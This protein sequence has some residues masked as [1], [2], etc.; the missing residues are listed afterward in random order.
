MRRVLVVVVAALVLVAAIIV[1][2]PRVLAQ[3]GPP[4]QRKLRAEHLT[5]AWVVTCTPAD[6]NGC[7]QKAQTSIWNI[8]ASG[9]SKVAIE[10]PANEFYRLA[11]T[12]DSEKRTMTV[13]G[14]TGFLQGY[15]SNIRS[16]AQF[17]FMASDPQ[18]TEMI[19]GRIYAT[20]VGDSACAS[21]ALCKATKQ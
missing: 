7:N 8:T 21:Q 14:A 20:V 11:G 6:W 16:T 19:G 17:A 10:I 5:G 3:P 12:F 15:C 4:P 13:N 9:D 1:L 2:A 18:R